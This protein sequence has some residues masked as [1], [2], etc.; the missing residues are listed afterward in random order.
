MTITSTEGQ[1]F[2]IGLVTTADAIK[3][4]ANTLATSILIA[5]PQME[6]G[7]VATSYIPTNGSPVTRA[8]DVVTHDVAMSIFRLYGVRDFVGPMGRRGLLGGDSP[9][10]ESI[11]GWKGDKGDTGEPG[12]AVAKGDKGDSGE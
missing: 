9:P 7:Q 3:G 10:G 5:F 4:Q 8:A 11:Q 12:T 1:D 2:V 6:D